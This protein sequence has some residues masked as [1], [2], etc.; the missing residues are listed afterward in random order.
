MTQPADAPAAC[1]APPDT[2]TPDT[3]TPDTHTRAGLPRQRR[4]RARRPVA[5]TPAMLDG[6]PA[7]AA[8]PRE[9]SRYDGWTPERQRM[10]VK[11]LAEHG[12]VRR[13]AAALGMS[14]VGA[15]QLRRAPG[16]ED[17]ARAW[18]EA[19]AV[20]VE[21][22]ADAAMERALYGVP[23]PVFHKGEQVGERRW[24]ND[25]LAMFVLRHQDPERY[26]MTPGNRVPPHVRK[27]LRAEWERELAEQA[28][29]QE[30]ASEGRRD[31]LLEDLRRMRE[32]MRDYPPT[33]NMSL[34]AIMAWSLPLWMRGEEEE[35]EWE[36][37]EEELAELR[38]RE[39]DPEG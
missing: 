28:E 33:A 11:L 15:Y 13:A 35:Q 37:M 34:A 18:A 5:V 30:A 29:R 8:V 9:H 12:C 20:G 24:Y 2:H 1:D 6:A 19:Q 26:G 7:F 38:A 25:R 39:E 14:E 3:H 32:R 31:T 4:A 16:G 10:F 22:L 23:V 21:K 17:F 27:A 36:E